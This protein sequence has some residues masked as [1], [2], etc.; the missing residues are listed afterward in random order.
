MVLADNAG[1]ASCVEFVKSFGRPLLL[2]GGGG[3]TIRNV[4][5][6]W[7]LHPVNRADCQTYETAIALGV[8][9]S[10][11]VYLPIDTANPAVA[12]QRLLRV[13]WTRF[14]AAHHVRYDTISRTRF[15]SCVSSS[16]PRC[17]T[18]GVRPNNMDNQNTPEY[19]AKCRETIIENLRH[20]EGAPGVQMS[21][22]CENLPVRFCRLRSYPRVQSYV[23]PAR[24]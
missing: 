17:C 19:L 5:R 12:L 3:Y 7:V 1:H 21:G 11:E 10:D 8:S 24:I 6:C 9:L 14:S 13:L 18:D 16:V 15:N 4:A 2:L 22:L 20:V 23:L